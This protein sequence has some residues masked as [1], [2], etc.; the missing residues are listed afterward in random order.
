M[1]QNKYWDLQRVLDSSVKVG[2]ESRCYFNQLDCRLSSE[3]ALLVSV[4][5]QTSKQFDSQYTGNSYETLN[6]NIRI[7]MEKCRLT[8]TRWCSCKE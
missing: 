6:M 5:T 3:S 8:C 7:K 4:C 2:S 1:T